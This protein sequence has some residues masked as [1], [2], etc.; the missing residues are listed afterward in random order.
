MISMAHL[1]GHVFNLKFV[2][3]CSAFQIYLFITASE[4]QDRVGWGGRILASDC[5]WFCRSALCKVLS[6]AV[7]SY[8]ISHIYFFVQQ[9]DKHSIS[10]CA[11]V[12]VPQTAGICFRKLGIQQTSKGKFTVH[13]AAHPNIS[14]STMYHNTH[15]HL[16]LYDAARTN[17]CYLA[18]YSWVLTF[19]L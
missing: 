3:C 8:W 2:P 13:D 15:K 7:I 17:I 14:R 9:E 4:L 10:R 16:T 19:S 6:H 11:T 18:S 5:Q 1:I 12:G